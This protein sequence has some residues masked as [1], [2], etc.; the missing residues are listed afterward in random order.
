MEQPPSSTVLPIAGYVLA[1]GR[2]SRMG[3]DKSF[4]HLAGKPLIEHG[5]GK[6]RRICAAVHILGS[7][8][9]LAPYA[10]LVE[11]LHPGNGPLGG[12]E[13]ALAHTTH[14]WNLILPVDVPF[15][16]T[17]LLYARARSMLRSGPVG[18]RMAMFTVRGVPQPALLLV[19]R[20]VAPYI[21]RAV[22][23]GQ[24]KLFFVLEA[25]ACEIDAGIAPTERESAIRK[26]GV[27][28]M[29]LEDIHW[30]EPGFSANSP[31]EPWQR[32]AEAQQRNQHLWFANLNTP[33][34]FA[35]AEAHL[36]ALDT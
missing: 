10:P 19:H 7:N 20:E 8:P 15:F 1:G 13:A 18:V 4:L 33:A 11:D 32:T 14:D 12:I 16:P 21:A 22:A 34:D 6:L 5:V 36:D 2:S 17:A 30:G 24:R 29:A 28:A 31:G 35:E 9:A 3:S 25:A 27:D 26:A 23:E